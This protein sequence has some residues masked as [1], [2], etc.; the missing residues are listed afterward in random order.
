M[1]KDGIRGNE[2]LD[3]ISTNDEKLC[4]IA[5]PG[6]GKTFALKKRIEKLLEEGKDPSRML[7]VTFSRIAALDIKKELLELGLKGSEK[8]H[9]QTLHSFCFSL[10]NKEGVLQSIGRDTRILLEYEEKFM[11]NDLLHLG[12]GSITEL[13][14]RLSAFETAWAR[15]QTEEP[16]WPNNKKDRIFQKN[17]LD[18][19]NFHDCMIIGEIIPETYKY[20]RN[21]PSSFV[22]TNYDYIFIDEY[23]DLNKAEQK[24]LELLAQNGASVMVIGD[25]DQSIFE[26]LRHAHPEGILEYSKQISNGYKSLNTCQRCPQNVV[27]IATELISNNDIRYFTKD[28]ETIPEKAN[29]KITLIQ[30]RSLDEEVRGIVEYIKKTI[31]EETTDIGKIL[32]LSPSRDV[33]FMIREKLNENNIKALCFYT[34]QELK[35]GTI[36]KWEKSEHKQAF[37][38]L[39][40]LAHPKDKVALRSWLGF[41]SNNVRAPSYKILRD[42]CYDESEDIFNV[43]E[44]I[45]NEEINIPRLTPI[46]KEYIKLKKSINELKSLKGQELVDKLFPED[47]EWS[48]L[49]R[50]ILNDVDTNSSAFE[51]FEE[52]RKEI[53]QPEVPINVDYVRIMSLH[54]SK[55]LT[56]DLVIITSC[57][58]YLIPF[59]KRDLRGDD[60]KRQLEEQRRLF[61]VGITRTTNIL[62]I[63]SFLQ[64]PS[65]LAYKYVP[66]LMRRGGGFVRT[67]TSPFIFELGSKA[68][69]VISGDTWTF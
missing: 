6:T 62:V 10:L 5:G 65:E 18:W 17:L 34:E 19:L 15:L 20:I 28:L 37:T 36:K 24:L 60:R 9:A 69:K 48:N 40:L 68:P 56:A 38:L 7:V 35:K 22:S 47:K 53:T 61:Y 59:R 39:T 11:L 44:K 23:Q 46:V 30:W 26:S 1:W 31:V 41:G 25:D 13:E 42:Y 54:K 14:E 32:V 49:F 52:L 63:S 33:G 55:G 21:N 29:G 57:V 43:L 8:I 58:D 64:W 4:V 50:S 67:R 45:I 2:A 66:N 51:I 3:I 27:D 16:G 12:L